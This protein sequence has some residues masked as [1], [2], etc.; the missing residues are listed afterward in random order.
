MVTSVSGPPSPEKPT[1]SLDDFWQAAL[2]ALT[3]DLRTPLINILGFAQEMRLLC[4]ELKTVAA[5]EE[6][7]DASGRVGAIAAI[8]LPE[9]LSYVEAAG[10]EI[11]GMLAGLVQLSRS[12][13]RP[14]SWSTVSVAE[15]LT[16]LQTLQPS[17]RDAAVEASPS[18]LPTCAGDPGAVQEIFEHIL[19]NAV[20]FVRP[21]VPPLVRIT[22]DYADSLPVETAPAREDGAPRRWVVYEAAD[23][24]LGFDPRRKE[25]VFL[26]LRQLR[27][28]KTPGQGL[29]LAVVRGLAQRM[30]GWAWAES[31]PNQGTRIFVALPADRPEGT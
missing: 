29:G 6:S 22:A 11:D 23:N 12:M 7:P 3:H 5:R 19:G 21:G 4:N 10:K 28:G 13:R 24:G 16:T 15:V 20:K 30:H 26:P 17:L 2:Y 1:S 14:L 9:C 27:P 31:A 8:E 25:D 18:P